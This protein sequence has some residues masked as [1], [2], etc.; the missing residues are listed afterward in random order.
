MGVTGV[1]RVVRGWAGGVGGGGLGGVGGRGSG[2][3]VAGLVI[4]GASQGGSWGPSGLEGEGRSPVSPEG[5][6]G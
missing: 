2:F 6:R 3:A 4:A 1:S 5:G